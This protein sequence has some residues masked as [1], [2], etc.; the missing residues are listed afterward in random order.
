[1]PLGQSSL[2]LSG[3]EAGPGKSTSGGIPR[4]AVRRDSLQNASFASA[5][6]H[7]SEIAA[8]P[9][10][11][12]KAEGRQLPPPTQALAAPCAWMPAAPSA[13]SQNAPRRAS[14]TQQLRCQP[15]TRSLLLPGRPWALGA[16]NV[17][18]GK[19][20][21]EGLRSGVL[22]ITCAQQSH[23]QGGG[24]S[25]WNPAPTTAAWCDHTL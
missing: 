25:L 8:E 16:E 1:M 7:P 19:Q 24:G 2:R 21:T 10:S 22:S 4:G 15:G 13:V 9:R 18:A 14:L 11:R 6:Q 5:I 12:G 17:S 3:G 20:T 23:L